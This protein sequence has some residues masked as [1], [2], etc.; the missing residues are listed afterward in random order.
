MNRYDEPHTF[1][2]EGRGEFPFD[3]L[4]REHAWPTD[5]ASALV[6]GG[7]CLR[8]VAITASQLRHVTHGRW[9]SFGWKVVEG[10]TPDGYAIDIVDHKVGRV[11]AEEA[12]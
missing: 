4:R 11:E 3:M 9:E 8:R 6:M 2:V 12:A 5:T 7:R 1:I 10:F